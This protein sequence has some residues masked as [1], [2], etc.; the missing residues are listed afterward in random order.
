MFDS[1]SE[2]LSGTLKTLRGQAR[3]TEANIKDTLREVRMAL[4]EADVALPVVREFVD[5]VKVRALGENVM[6]SLTPG[7]ALIKIV[8]DELVKV[9]G[10]A[11]EE[12]RD[13]A[14]P[15]A[16]EGQ[17]QDAVLVPEDPAPEP[18]QHP[19]RSHLHERPGPRRVHGPDLV[20]EAYGLDQL[21]GEEGHHSR[22]I[23]G[24]GRRLGVREDRDSGRPEVQPGE[25]GRE[26]VA[27][28]R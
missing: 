7:Q 13:P 27:A 22:G 4:L 23:A 19:L 2:R 18:G 12:L 24:V 8:N 16:V 14:G 15:G 25:L 3:L 20:D 5:H 11:N 9:M 21:L 10:E 17:G 28:N 6:Q 1:L 26:A